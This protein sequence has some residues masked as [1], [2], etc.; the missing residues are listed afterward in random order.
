MPAFSRLALACASATL[1][2]LVLQGCGGGGVDSTDCAL[3]DVKLNK[4]P[5]DPT[6]TKDY[7]LSGRLGF[8]GSMF[9]DQ[10]C[11][12]GL[13][14]AEAKAVELSN[15]GEDPKTAMV[16]AQNACMGPMAKMMTDPNNN[17]MSAVAEITVAMTGKTVGSGKCAVDVPTSMAPQEAFS[18]TVDSF[19]I[20]GLKDDVCSALQTIAKIQKEKGDAASSDPAYQKANMTVGANRP[21]AASVSVKISMV[22][23]QQP[24]RPPLDF[25]QLAGLQK[26]LGEV[27]TGMFF[28]APPATLAAAPGQRADFVA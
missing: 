28:A 9:K 19:S 11:C 12:Q 8:S 22:A 5:G 10:A 16:P 17:K 25:E 7:T 21:E 15:K 6:M 1:T 27:L 14:D 4:I 18:V 23:K 3:P 13:K 26:D 2:A 20:N 24:P